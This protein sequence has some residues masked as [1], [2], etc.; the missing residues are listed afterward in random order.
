M[1]TKLTFRGG[2]SFILSNNFHSHHFFNC[3]NHGTYINFGSYD[4]Y[5]KK[6][7]V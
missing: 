2:G 5:V 4:K 1:K 6:L 3:A 7:G